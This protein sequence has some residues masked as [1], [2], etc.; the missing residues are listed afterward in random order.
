MKEAIEAAQRL[1]DQVLNTTVGEGSQ[2]AYDDYA[3]V[4]N[5]LLAAPAVEEWGIR[6]VLGS[7]FECR[8]E[9]HARAMMRSTSPVIGPMEGREVVS[10]RVGPWTAR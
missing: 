8:D 4:R 1:A 7:V 10:R 9:A 5:A 6:G 3:V 2:R